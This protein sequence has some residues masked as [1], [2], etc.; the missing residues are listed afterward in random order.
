[1]AVMYGLW[2][3]VLLQ[4][5]HHAHVH[6]KAFGRSSALQGV[7]EDI[8]HR[9][10]RIARQSFA[11]HGSMDTEIRWFAWYIEPNPFISVVGL[12]FVYR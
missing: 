1:M 7:D 3:D 12:Y 5:L 9:A 4:R 6:T 8:S 11:V 2:Q 10:F